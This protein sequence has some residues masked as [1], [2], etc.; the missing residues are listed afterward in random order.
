MDQKRV[1]VIKVFKVLSVHPHGRP[2]NEGVRGVC[3]Y[4]ALDEFTNR[5]QV[6]VISNWVIVMG[7][8]SVKEQTGRQRNCELW[9]LKMHNTGQVNQVSKIIK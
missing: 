3:S 9:M 8:V 1:K 4:S 6:Q 7:C 2:D 5:C